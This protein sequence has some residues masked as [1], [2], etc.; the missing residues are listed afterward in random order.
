MP[1]ASYSVIVYF[2]SFFK[3]LISRLN[4]GPTLDRLNSRIGWLSEQSYLFIG[5]LKAKEHQNL[6]FLEYNCL[7]PNYCYKFE[8][9]VEI[10]FCPPAFNYT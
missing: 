4:L 3:L 8:E 7:T 6:N 9:K 1:G 10:Y 2:V 5:S